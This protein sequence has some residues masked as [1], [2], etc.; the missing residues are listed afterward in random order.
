MVFLQLQLPNHKHTEKGSQDLRIS[1]IEKKKCWFLLYTGQQTDRE[2]REKGETKTWSSPD[3]K[4]IG[5]EGM[6]YNK[7]LSLYL[8]V[9]DFEKNMAREKDHKE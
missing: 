2:R 1:S 8:G 3:G 9:L 5:H 7:S 6:Q 4:F